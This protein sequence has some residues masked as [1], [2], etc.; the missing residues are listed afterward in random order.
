MEYILVRMIIGS[1]VKVLEMRKLVLEQGI[2]IDDRQHVCDAGCADQVGL[3]ER[4]EPADVQLS[5]P[6]HLIDPAH[7]CVCGAA[8][9][10]VGHWLESR[11]VMLGWVSLGLR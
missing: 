2:V 7:A 9:E 8:V 6:R 10:K 11:G 3:I 5:C 4:V 1:N